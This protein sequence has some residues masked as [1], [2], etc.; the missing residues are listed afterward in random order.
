MTH[1]RITSPFGS[2][3]VYSD[4]HP[5]VFEEV[6]GTPHAPRRQAPSSITPPVDIYE[7]DEAV[8][9]TL[10]LP[11]ATKEGIHVSV[12][13]GTLTINAECARDEK[14]GGRW[15]RHERQMGKYVRN[16][17][18]GSYVDANDISGSYKD[19]ILE[20]TIPKAG[21]AAAQSVKIN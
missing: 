4:E 18:L 3:F 5:N 19:G 10:A 17:H 21:S 1:D 9:L 7:T 20:L 14:E 15:V 6:F 16:L 13:D 8:T 2:V 11:G 12:A